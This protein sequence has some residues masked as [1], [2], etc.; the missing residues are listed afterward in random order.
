MF[1]P[2]GFD[3]LKIEV[4]GEVFLHPDIFVKVILQKIHILYETLTF[5]GIETCLTKFYGF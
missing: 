5:V 3:R 1:T 4:L 2:T